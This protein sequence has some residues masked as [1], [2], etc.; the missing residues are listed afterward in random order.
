MIFLI[1]KLS[2]F[3]LS[4][5]TSYLSSRELLVRFNGISQ[6]SSLVPL[7][8]LKVLTLVLFYLYCFFDDVIDNLKFAI[9]FIFAE[10]TLLLSL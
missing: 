6:N 7:E 5:G 4:G 1:Y 8:F 3:G 2:K 10:F 9:I